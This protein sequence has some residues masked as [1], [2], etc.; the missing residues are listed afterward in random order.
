VSKDIDMN[1]VN[2]KVLY[3]LIGNQ[4]GLSEKRKLED[5]VEALKVLKELNESKEM[6]FCKEGKLLPDKGLNI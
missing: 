3:K 4:K 1:L 5:E 2:K 6:E